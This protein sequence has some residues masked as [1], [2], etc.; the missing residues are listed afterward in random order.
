[1]TSSR[2]VM[3]L[4]RPDFDVTIGNSGEQLKRQASTVNDCCDDEGFGE[5]VERCIL[6]SGT[7]SR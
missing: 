5:A 4:K 7:R 6:D 1:M 3:M 2:N